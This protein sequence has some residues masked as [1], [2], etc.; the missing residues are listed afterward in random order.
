[1]VQYENLQLNVKVNGSVLPAE[2]FIH[3][4]NFPYKLKKQKADAFSHEFVKIQKDL[5]FYIEANGFRSKDYQITVIPKPALV[6]FDAKLDYP[7]HTGRQD[8]TLHNTGDMV[9]P[10]GTRVK[11]RFE[12]NNT[13]DI[14]IKF[15]KNK[16]EA[17][18]KKSKESFAYGK[19]LFKDLSYTLYLSNDRLKNADSISYNISVIPDAYPTISAE[20][21][22]DS[23]DDKY[24]YF[25]GDAADD[26]GIKTLDFNYAIER[27]GRQG[28]TQ[29]I[30]VNIGMSKKATSFTHNWDLNLLELEPGD[31]LTYFF[32]VWDNDAVSGGKSARTQTMTYKLPTIEELDNRAEAN[33]EQLK[34][35][36]EEVFE[37]AKKLREKAKDLQE[38][39]VQKKELNWEDK[40]K[41][42]ELLKQ[43]QNM[44]QKMENME[45]MFNENRKQ[46]E[47]YKQFSE[48]MQ[49]KKDKLQEMFE[50]VMNDELR[51]MM[52]KLE[53]LLEE[54]DKEE[55]MEEMENFEMT[56]EQLEKEMDRLMELF[57]QMEFEQKMNETIDK[58][59][60]LAEKQEELSEE[61]E[62]KPDGT[63]MEEEEKKQEELNEEFDKIKEDMEELDKMNKELGNK[64]DI[65][66]ETEQQQEEIS[67]DQRES[68]EQMEQQN[69]QNASEKQKSAAK[70][71]QQMANQLSMMQMQ[72]QMDQMQEDMEAIRQLL[73]N[74]ITL[75]HDQED[76]MKRIS[77]INVN[78]PQY[79][80]LVQEQ[81]KLRDD[82]EIVED[83][84]VAL[85][86][87][88][89]QLESFIMKELGEM[90]RNM[91]KS[92]ENLGERR[93]NEAN[94][95][96]Q[97]VMT[98]L[99]NLALML[100][101]SMQQMQQQMAMKM[102]GN[103][104]CQNPGSSPGGKGMKGMQKQLNDQIKQL[105]GDMK[106]GKKPG[107]QM[108]KEAAQLAAKQA[109]LRKALEKL[110]KEQ[111]K[112]GKK[113][114][115]DLEKLAEDM[116]KTEEDLVN[117]RITAETLKRQQD[118]LTRLLR[119][120]NAQ[121]ERELDDKRLAKTAQPKT[122]KT[123]PNVEEYLKKRQAE[124]ELYKTVPPA[125]KPYYKSLVE[126][127]FNGIKF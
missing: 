86:K 29:K 43:H 14:Y 26:Y 109:A 54:M 104:Q 20:E 111:N 8:E 2:A 18:E 19:R 81:Q 33:N 35:N 96:Q 77:D 82:A 121:R 73:E 95:N 6:S 122:R 79:V 84:L 117:K 74:L 90:N 36:M 32:E 52:E 49:E 31:K 106:A 23:I 15:G 47:E 101:E 41:I 120:E 108:S 56:E 9:V 39:M 24:L 114:M 10:A 5:N 62:Q 64:E 21:M 71:M 97:F 60:E 17:V 61:T 100:D 53:K 44:Q 28:A 89:F 27:K 98:S 34:E 65:K 78:T 12:A 116:E 91:E 16:P 87:R 125:L 50:Q 76:V 92:A 46:Q 113:S 22:R 37:D 45:N 67:E 1:M 115:G 70:K 80:T 4:N 55:I 13:D 59:E 99:N 118:I 69:S 38:K 112:D 25:I 93:V 42:E 103:Q 48:S 30:P 3:Y 102:Q 85:S 124:I 58:L 66:K 94:A 68:M 40:A 63:N 88:V 72:M 127:Y 83:S 51:E 119:A 107:G 110:N 57:K 75:S 126:Q 105:Q 7:S 123:P 11:W